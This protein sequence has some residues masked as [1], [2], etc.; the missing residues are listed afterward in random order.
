[1]GELPSR[2]L[3]PLHIG[4][5]TFPHIYHLLFEFSAGICHPISFNIHV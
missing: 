3:T 5:T 1:M 2:D 4:S